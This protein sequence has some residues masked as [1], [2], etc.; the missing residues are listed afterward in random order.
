MRSA[1]ACAALLVVALVS[2]AACGGGATDAASTSPT[3]V[4]TPAPSAEPTPTPA[5]TPIQ[6]ADVQGLLDRVRES[7]GAPG[8]LAVLRVG[9]RRSWVASGT[10][11]TAGTPITAVTRFRIASITKPIV[12]ALVLDAVAR[13]ELDL[14]A[15]VGDLLADLVPDVLRADPPITVRQLLAHTSGVFDVS[16]DATTPEAIAADIAKLPEPLRTEAQAALERYLAGEQ[17][18]APDVVIVALSEGHDREFA[19]GAGYHYSNTGYQLAAMVLEK[20]TGMP[21]ADL[22]RTRVVEPLGLERT[23][24]APPDVASP[25]LRGYGTSTADGSLVDVTDDLVLF[26]NGGNGGVISTADELLATMQAI[27]GGRLLPAEL[28]AEMKSPTS[29]SLG[30]YGLGLV[31]YSLS[32]G[33]F[34]GHEGGVNGTASIA[35]V[36]PDG[37]DGVVVALNLRSGRDLRLP[38]L[39]D[40]MLCGGR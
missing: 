35:M 17:V 10:A 29:M 39:A 9:D 5:A 31:T 3:S 2:L 24:I 16:N 22:L 27:V 1:R 20:A 32:C 6:P 26:G 15:V 7:Y 33:T 18:I 37:S 30:T 40:L 38:M 12:A 13:G 4:P 14:D 34:Y 28:V 21:L 25:D 36:S 19:P 23:T 8:A 11:D